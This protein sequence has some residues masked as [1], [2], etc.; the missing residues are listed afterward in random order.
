MLEA[1]KKFSLNEG[2]ILT[3][4]REDEIKIENKEIKIKPAWKWLLNN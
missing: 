4:D 2:L 3:F 1:M